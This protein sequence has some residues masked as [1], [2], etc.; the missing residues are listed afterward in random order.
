[1]SFSSSIPRSN[2]V[3]RVVRVSLVALLAVGTAGASTAAVASTLQLHIGSTRL[4]R[5]LADDA[6]IDQSLPL[7]GQVAADAG[8]VDKS[9][10]AA[11]ASTS[12]SGTRSGSK[13]DAGV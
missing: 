10:D 3:A 8:P 4:Q 1:M 6:T 11:A 5:P 7:V 9:G 12:T 2:G 13:A